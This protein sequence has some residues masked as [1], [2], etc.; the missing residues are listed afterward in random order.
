[1]ALPDAMAEMTP[2]TLPALSTA[3]ERRVFATL[4]P[5]P[6]RDAGRALLAGRARHRHPLRARALVDPARRRGER[7]ALRCGADRDLAARRPRDRRTTPAFE[8]RRHRRALS[9]T[10]SGCGRD[11]AL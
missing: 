7:D 10:P 6:K 1:M 8:A 11:D 9:Q 4:A 3:G 2:D 5:A